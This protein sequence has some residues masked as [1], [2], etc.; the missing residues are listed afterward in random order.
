MAGSPAPLPSLG[1]VF[2]RFLT[3]DGESGTYVLTRQT[4]PE[5]LRGR[6]LDS[7]V[8]TFAHTGQAADVYKN[9]VRIEGDAGAFAWA[10]ADAGLTY[11]APLGQSESAAPLPSLASLFVRATDFVLTADA[12]AYVLMGAPALS[13]VAV[14]GEAGTLSMSGQAAGL[15]YG[16]QALA[17]QAGS[18]TYTG[19][20]AALLEQNSAAFDGDAGAF[21]LTG[22]DAALLQHHVL[23]GDAA[24]F[25]WAGADN[26]MRAV[27][28][29]IGD[30]TAYVWGGRDATPRRGAVNAT[31]GRRGGNA[32]PRQ[33]QGS[34]RRNIQL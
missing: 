33:R 34:T 3:V 17:P 24:G 32:S 10:G 26:D 2:P 6:R 31:F 9:L 8:G 30:A 27:R 13:D 21:V 16:R 29:L 1:L 12:G 11:F 18:Y 5:L 25:A 23:Q 22:F 4:T 7:A 19:W 20:P 15:L 14:T 28:R